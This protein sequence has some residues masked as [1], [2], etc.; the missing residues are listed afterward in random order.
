[1]FGKKKKMPRPAFDVTQKDVKTWWG[2][3]KT[4]PTTEA[5]QKMMKARILAVYPEA[6]IL[7]SELK[8]RKDIEWVDRIEELDALLS[9]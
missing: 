3:K 1:M 2:G 6:T 5:E 7:D 9:D 4:V 8:K